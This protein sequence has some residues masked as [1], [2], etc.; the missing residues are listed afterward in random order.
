[1]MKRAT[2]ALLALALTA[3]AAD[4][5]DLVTQSQIRPE[6]FHNSNVMEI[7]CGLAGFSGPRL[8]GSPNMKRANEWTRDKLTEFGLSNAHLGPWGPFGTGLT[9]ELCA[10]RLVAPDVAQLWALPRAWSASTNGAVRGV[11]VKVKL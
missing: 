5:P 4:S 9:Y 3:S 6:G 7:A 10:L 1:P 11:P 2:F 8:T